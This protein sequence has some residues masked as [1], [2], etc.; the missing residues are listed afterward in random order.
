[1]RQPF[2]VIPDALQR[3]AL[4]CR[5]GTSIRTWRSSDNPIPCLRRTA[6]R[7]AAHAMTREA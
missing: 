2:R 5:S 6:S 3:K 4:L 1:M 7:C